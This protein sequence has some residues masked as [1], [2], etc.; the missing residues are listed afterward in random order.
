[1]E[2]RRKPEGAGSDCRGA[3]GGRWDGRVE[4][5]KGWVGGVGSTMEGYHDAALLS[6]LDVQVRGGGGAA[7]RLHASCRHVAADAEV[8]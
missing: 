5:P 2:A 1:V 6:E 3:V 7:E 4:K 8:E